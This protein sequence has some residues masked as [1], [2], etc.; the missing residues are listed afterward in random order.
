LEEE[1]LPHFLLLPL[2]ENALKYGRAT[3]PDRVGVRLS[4]RREDGRRLVIE[5][6]NT[7]QWIEPQEK[8]TV[9][10]LGI[11]LENLRKRLRRHYAHAHSLE[12]SQ[13]NGWVT[14]TLRLRTPPA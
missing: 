4:A 5:V 6:A 3:S 11:G 14:V 2:V 8:K 1:R 7:G 12:I 9:A 10:S 13:A